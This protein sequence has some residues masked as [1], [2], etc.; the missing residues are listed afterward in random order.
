[1]A[2]PVVKTFL[3]DGKI[4]IDFGQHWV[5]DGST[6]GSTVHFVVDVDAYVVELIRDLAA[7]L[8]RQRFIE[9][10]KPPPNTEGTA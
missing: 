2:K 8:S 9:S 4:V 7:T 6:N 1:M 3:Q 5:D 10:M